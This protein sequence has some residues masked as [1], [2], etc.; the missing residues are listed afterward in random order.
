MSDKCAAIIE[1]HRAGK[2][3]S[4]IVK[5]LK[6]PKSTVYHTVSR[7][8]ELQSIEDRPQ[9][10]RPRSSQM[11][12]MINAVRARIRCNP[13]RSMKAMACDMNASERTIRNIVKNRFKDVAS[14]NANS[15]APHRPP[16]KKK[17]WLERRFFLTNCRLQGRYG[18][19]RDH[20][21]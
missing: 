21:L 14:Q 6:A 17:D 3:N 12:K 5:L 9:S 13:K 10:E 2:T 19:E 11:P 1:L 16:K 8:K 18:H 20:F 4:E 7:F 15:S